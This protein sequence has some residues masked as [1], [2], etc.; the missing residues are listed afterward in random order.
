MNPD[1]LRRVALLEAKRRKLRGR[2]AALFADGMEVGWTA[3]RLPK[4]SPAAWSWH[5]GYRTARAE[6]KRRMAEDRVAFD[7]AL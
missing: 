7:L 4:D 6:R 2:A 3:W 5:E 1:Y